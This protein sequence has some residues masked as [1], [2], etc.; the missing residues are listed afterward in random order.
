MKK[1]VSTQTAKKIGLGL[2]INMLIGS[3]V[4]VGIFFKNNNVFINNDH[5]VIAILIAWLISG[6][7]S[8][9][10]AISFAEVGSSDTSHA[11]LGGWCENL[12]S[13]NFGR[14]IKII[15]PFFY[16]ILIS[17]SIS[18]FSAEAILNIF[19]AGE[20]VHI[21]VVFVMAFILFFFFLGLNF[22]SLKTSGRFQNVATFL[23]FI[24]ML[25]VIIAGIIY[26]S[27]NSS[28]NLFVEFGERTDKSINFVGILIS[29]PSILFAFDS[30]VSVGNMSKDMI[31]P[32]RNV[33]IAVIVSMTI[34]TVFYLLVTI[35]QACSN[36]GDIYTLFNKV[37][38]DPNT[39]NAIR[40]I[41][42][43]FIF[44]C[45]IGVMNS[46]CLVVIRSCNSL[47]EEN[48]I[49]NARQI[50][51]LANRLLP[52]NSELKPGTFLA[53][54]FYL[55]IFL[56]LLIPSCIL[57]TDAY[58]DGISNLP[59]TFFFSIYATVILFGIINRKTKK[60]QVHKIKGFLF[61]APIA[62]IGCYLVFFFQVFYT[63]TTATII[64]PTGIVNWGLFS[65]NGYQVH[66]WQATIV[67]FIYFV[68]MAIYFII[69]KVMIS[70]QTIKYQDFRL[71]AIYGQ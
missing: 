22:F 5:N 65:T 49:M 11:G 8:L 46:F 18:I 41:L 39:Q 67:F 66:N 7:I 27:Q 42:S 54:V 43:I 55:F 4:G 44:I 28:N 32:K 15:Q 3:V 40:I 57:N 58:I 68:F 45:I 16:F 59:T 37:I 64:N 53:I 70:K 19:G 9:F 23:K 1:T 20:K 71:D 21:G 6:I 47:I 33:P 13:R 30:F 17:F 52:T 50:K 29:L 60:R 61:Y 48:L 25:M 34:V 2:A 10:T 56:M 35:G 51:T 62:V 63:F 14:F 26:G 69:N 38:S 12:I 36:S 24:P 31:N